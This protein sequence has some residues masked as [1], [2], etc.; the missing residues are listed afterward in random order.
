MED[1]KKKTAAIREAI[2]AA[3]AGP[4]PHEIVVFSVAQEE[5][6]FLTETIESVDMLADQLVGKFSGVVA[7]GHPIDEARHLLNGT[8]VSGV[9]FVRKTIER[10]RQKAHLAGFTEGLAEARKDDR[11]D[12][13]TSYL[14][15]ELDAARRCARVAEVDLA[16]ARAEL[17]AAREEA[18]GQAR[19][20]EN[21]MR[22]R[23]ECVREVDRYREGAVRAGRSAA[24]AAAALEK[25]QAE[26]AALKDATSVRTA[27]QESVR[28]DAAKAERAEKRRED[29]ARFFQRVLVGVLMFLGAVIARY[30]M[31]PLPAY[32]APVEV[33][34]V[35][36][37]R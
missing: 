27:I 6:A 28:H 30:T 18:T 29:L 15:Q 7:D 17:V 20:N 9:E 24:E 13:T 34:P 36:T 33:A 21:L 23:E 14:R 5:V 26:H 3:T 37:V 16:A 22:N 19:L 25:L 2:K 32:R 4:G 8:S 11:V 1:W 35:Q 12:M 31:P 10:E